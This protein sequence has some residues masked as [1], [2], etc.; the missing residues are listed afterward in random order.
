MH[1][2]SRA[3]NGDNPVKHAIGKS[4]QSRRHKRCKH[5]QCQSNRKYFRQK[6]SV[7]SF[8]WV[9]ACMNEISKP[10]TKA[11]PSIGKHNFMVTTMESCI[12]APT[13]A[14]F[15]YQ[16]GILMMSWYACTTRSRMA[17]AVCKV[18]SACERAV[19]TSVRLPPPLIAF[20]A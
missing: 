14:S 7:D 16:I 11:T 12:N 20:I 13:S 9:T 17:V 8:I 19:T 2:G 6:A 4:R 10:T 18:I 15:M 5:H 1:Q 3:T